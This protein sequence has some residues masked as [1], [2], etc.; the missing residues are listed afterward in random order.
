[1]TGLLYK[2]GKDKAYLRSSLSTVKSR[3]VLGAL[4]GTKRLGRGANRQD[5]RGY[6]KR[7]L[8][9]KDYT[10]YG[11]ALGPRVESGATY[12]YT[13]SLTVHLSEG[14]FKREISGPTRL[15]GPIQFLVGLLK[16]WRLESENAVLLLGQERSYDTDKLL[17]GDAQLSGRDVKDRIACLFRIRK[18]LSSLFRDEDTENAWLRER[19]DLLNGQTPMELLL[20]G[21]MENILTV[22][23]YVDLAAGR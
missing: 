9:W 3:N 10:G 1:M 23:E 18:T 6:Q 5:S 2:T 15:S 13:K 17:H 20:E 8:P 11:G 19:H 14:L 16:T 7:D 12:T 21:S 4:L 22:R